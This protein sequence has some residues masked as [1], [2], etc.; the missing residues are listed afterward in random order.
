MLDSILSAEMTLSAFLICELTAM[1]LGF[2]VALVYLFRDRH[3]GAFSQSLALL[4][5][6]VTLV[7]MLVN[8]NIGAGLAV[9]G[10]FA[11]VRFRSAPG[12]AKEITGLFTAVAVGLACGMG[13]VGVAVIF[14]VLM[15]VY[16][17][18]LGNFR[19]GEEGLR[20]RHLKITIP[21]TA[22]YETLF[23]DLFQQ[24]TTRHELIKVRTTNMG[25]LYELHYQIELKDP[26][27][28]RDFV[29]AIRCRNGNLNIV[30]GREAEKDIM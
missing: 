25:T 23:E 26:R 20:H 10:T 18:L 14:F 6:V 30:L 12:S 11:L 27:H 21:E 15:A 9:A 22:D 7:I 19:F 5:G 24:Y 4:P 13:Y 2:G 29:D 1:V 17:L 3:T 28:T 16:V 8:G